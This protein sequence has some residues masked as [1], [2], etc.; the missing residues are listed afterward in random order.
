MSSRPLYS[1]LDLE[2][3]K[4]FSRDQVLEAFGSFDERTVDKNQ[5]VLQVATLLDPKRV[6]GLSEAMALGD[7]DAIT[8]A[9]L[10]V[11][12]GERATVS[13][14]AN[15]ETLH[16]AEDVL[17]HKFKFYSE[18]HQLPHD[19]DWDFNPGTAHW[20][21]DL[22]RFSY[23][24][25][26]NRAYFATKDERFSQKAIG[27]ILDWIDKCEIERC[28]EGTPYVFGSYLNNAIHCAGWAR[29]VQM[30]LPEGQVSGE[31]L[32]RIL[33]SL[34][35]QIAYLEVVT[36]G[37]AGNWPTIGCQGI[38]Q[39]LAALPVFRD[40][41]RWIDYCIETL[42]KQIDAQIL[43]DG[44]QD[45]LTPHYHAVVVN[46]L[47]TACESLKVLGRELNRQTLETLRKLVHY[48]QQTV[49]PNGSAQVA[50]NDSDPEAVPKIVDRLK[51]LGMDDYISDPN[52]LGPEAFP[53][54]GVAFLRQKATDGDLYLAFDG[55][56][57]GRSHQH[58][59][60]LGFW[61]YAYGRSLIVDPGRH[62]YD[63]SEASYIP[64][65]RT[66]QAHSTIVV[67]G[68]G[69]NSRAKRDTWIAK[70]P[71]SL[72]FSM[73]EDEVR[74][75]SAYD[76]GYG[77][78]NAI[79]VVHQREIVFVQEKFWM[80]FDRV[81]GE[82]EHTLESRFHFYPG[83]VAVEGS[84]AM[85][86][87]DD[88]NVLL[89][90]SSDWDD[91]H[92]EKGQENPRSGWYSASYSLIEPAPCLSLFCQTILPFTSATLLL[93]YQGQKVPHVQF[94][95]HD[96]G[97]TVRLNGETIDVQTTLI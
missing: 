81:V 38:L 17:T 85:T 20:S 75:S 89:W 25:I 68:E 12:K 58:E 71:G 94:E 37:H 62:L 8:Q 44:V 52:Q 4:T 57:F 86:Q 42:A 50:F 30:L 9:V 2:T 27:L 95:A 34:H 51:A 35:D 79:A 16:L 46:N 10:H 39:T 48:Q 19:L 83:D 43:P 78:D 77:S 32:L 74:A 88:A 55:G 76:L 82:G 64:Y 91:V 28:F 36:N 24:G 70:A 33:K 96:R 87:Y 66:T 47:L 80:V 90:S 14:E 18:T 65:L 56:P 67:D 53:Y 49:V 97:A 7:T 73:S 40:T 54:A 29:C 13:A 72:T 26:L 1:R 6:L 93:P 22:N 63:N 84:R 41:D 92:V 61:L 59:D 5:F 69:Q 45:E 23:L 15:D 3:L 60:K 21:H 31:A 11:C